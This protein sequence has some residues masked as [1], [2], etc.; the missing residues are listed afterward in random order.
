MSNNSS[1]T[2]PLSLP[3]AP[4]PSLTCEAKEM[5]FFE[6]KSK[7]S[8]LCMSWKRVDGSFNEFQCYSKHRDDGGQEQ[9]EFALTLWQSTKEDTSKC[10]CDLARLSGCPRVFLELKSSFFGLPCPRLP[11]L[12]VPPLPATFDSTNSEGIDHR[13]ISHIVSMATLPDSDQTRQARTM[14]FNLCRT[15]TNEELREALNRSMG[16]HLS[17]LE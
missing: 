6:V 10:L 13:A 8:Q 7:L 11:P 17:L 1:T 14:I 5:S 15:T 4:F 2:F 9:T 3:L 16:L 12:R